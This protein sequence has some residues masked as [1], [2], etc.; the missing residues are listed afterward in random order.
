M[1]QSLTSTMASPPA[2][3][4]AIGD[5]LKVFLSPSYEFP[6]SRSRSRRRPAHYFGRGTRTAVF[7]V[8]DNH[9]VLP[10]ET[11]TKLLSFDFEIDCCN[12][13]DDP[14]VGSKATVGSRD[15]N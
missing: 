4:K 5:C 9:A 11:K 14:I 1:Y 10:R 7:F 8:L 15:F 6:R 12:N 13:L 2:N 3:S